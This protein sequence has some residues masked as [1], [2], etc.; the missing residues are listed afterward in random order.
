M[1]TVYLARQVDLDR[2]VALKELTTFLRVQLE[3]G[4]ASSVSPEWLAR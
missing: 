3:P 1:A 4:T 2:L